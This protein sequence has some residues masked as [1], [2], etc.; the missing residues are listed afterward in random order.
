TAYALGQLQGEELAAVKA[1][2]AASGADA[3]QHQVREIEALAAALSASRLGE[4]AIG[5]SAELRKAIGQHFDR[6]EPAAPKVELPTRRSPRARWAI[7]GSVV[8]ACLLILLL[9][10]VVQSRREAARR[11]QSS[12]HLRQLG[13]ALQN[14][15][16]TFSEM[17]NG[18]RS[19]AGDQM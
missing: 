12:N 13:I 19:N 6:N 5:V 1:R 15:H 11:A 7:V 14:H 4:P 17:P 8:A 18:A 10:P 3:S 2:L 16:D 9:V